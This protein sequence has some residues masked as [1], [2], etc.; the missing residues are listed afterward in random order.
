[1]ALEL[2]G[3][4]VATCNN[5][6]ELYKN[7]RSAGGMMVTGGGK[8]FVAMHQMIAAGNNPNYHGISD[9]VGGDG[10]QRIEYDIANGVI[11]NAEILYVSPTTDIAVQI[12]KDIAR[13]VL[14][15][16]EEEMSRMDMPQIEQAVKTAFP[17]LHFV[18][19]QGLDVDVLYQDKNGVNVNVDTATPD[20]VILDEVHRSGAPKFKEAVGRLFGYNTVEGEAVSKKENYPEGKDKIQLLSISA[21]PERD[22]DDVD[23]IRYWNEL[24][25]DYTEEE[26]RNMDD[27]AIILGLPEAVREG[28]ITPPEIIAFDANLVDTEQYKYLVDQIHNHNISPSMRSE[29]KRRVQTINRSIF[30]EDFENF[31]ELNEEEQERIKLERN[32]AVVEQAIRDGKLNLHGKYLIFSKSRRG[33][34]GQVIEEQD[35]NEEQNV[36]DNASIAHL[37]KQYEIIER[38]I[39]GAVGEELEIDSRYLSSQGQ[40]GSVN[41]ENLNVFDER[42]VT[43]DSTL[44]FLTATQKLDE[45]VH[46][47]GLTGA[48]ML[49]PIREAGENISLRGQSIRFLQEVGRTMSAGTNEPRVLFDYCNNVFRQNISKVL[50][51]EQMIDAFDLNPNQRLLAETYRMMT[52]KIPP[53]GQ[54]S[55]DYAELIDVL[56][57]LRE[58]HR[59]LHAGIIKGKLSEVLDREEFREH[60]D[61]ILEKI[62]G[63]GLEG[64]SRR[65]G[66]YAIGT[67][68]KKARELL[69]SK[70]FE[71]NKGKMFSTFNIKELEELGIF[72]RISPEGR[73]AYEEG[74][75]SL[76]ANGY[77]VGSNLSNLMFQHI[78]TGTPY[79]LDGVDINGF[80]DGQFDER[81][82]YDE[83]GFNRRGFN[84]RGIH[85]ETGTIHDERGFMADGTNILTG[86]DRDKLGYDYHGYKPFE[87]VDIDPETK[88]RKK[89]VDVLV[90]RKGLFH[91]VFIDPETKEPDYSKVSPVGEQY[92]K[93]LNG[94]KID[95]HGFLSTK[96]E[97]LYTTAEYGT[98]NGRGGISQY[99]IKRIKLREGGKEVKYV[100]AYDKSGKA[101]SGYDVYHLVPGKNPLYA[102]IPGRRSI[103]IDGFDKNGFNLEGIHRD[104]GTK[105]NREG[106]TVED[107]GK[108]AQTAEGIIS[109]FIASEQLT[110]E[111]ASRL[112]LDLEGKDII[113]G[114][115]L[116]I[117][118][119]S[120]LNRGEKSFEDEPNAYGF[121]AREI[122]VHV[123]DKPIEIKYKEKNGRLLN[124]LGTDF[125]GRRPSG[126]LHDS[127]IMLGEYTKACIEGDMDDEAFFEKTAKE[128]RMLVNDVRKKVRVD[129]NKAFEL[130]RLCPEIRENEEVK[131]TFD[132]IFGAS[133]EK[134]EEKVFSRCPKLGETL[135]T[136]IVDITEMI[137]SIGNKLRDGSLNLEDRQKKEQ[138]H[139][140]LLEKLEGMRTL[141]DKGNFD[142]R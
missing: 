50:A 66:S 113:T 92:Y 63:R 38:L 71:E 27:Y 36:E 62:T 94:K 90:D 37:R 9:V 127:L 64:I 72:D 11:N 58:Y 86:T 45:G 141:Y 33:A 126:R 77:V 119:F 115:N 23:M 81:T 51:P 73:K 123:F 124:I 10:R 134:L 100:L 128:K 69:N 4:Q 55:E 97:N 125:G 88:E 57:I 139:R 30:G 78:D 26:L 84:E 95:S 52:Q 79:N 111:L 13:F 114:T 67:K 15:F 76:D 106:R 96:S 118:G 70:T 16:S 98:I 29:F 116:D 109:R 14:G 61:E 65:P 6:N 129:M 83:D 135:R 47:K 140:M 8:S 21:T 101:F 5:L 130:F 48:F 82:G 32:T 142:G 2:Y 35:G 74:C 56:D 99:R 136:D 75:I 108:R 87:F 42:V 25:G 17:N 7:H 105:H 68:L 104:T 1:M 133:P 91:K 117:Y 31:H 122:P 89:I 121:V 59:P 110:E 43:N 138:E 49:K 131:A 39:T 85:R 93:L 22:V 107:F 112:G 12:Q 120:C 80:R 20:L 41:K 103:D 19:Y 137:R 60:R 3:H 28:I 18:C 54:L 102:D 53:R 132:R 46:V 40:R 34:D 44:S 24:L